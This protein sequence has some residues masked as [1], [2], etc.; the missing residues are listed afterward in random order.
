MDKKINLKINRLN[1]K[2]YFVVYYDLNFAAK[3]I[4]NFIYEDIDPKDY[5]ATNGIEQNSWYAT[6]YV[7]PN[8]EQEEDGAVSSDT[9]NGDNNTEGTVSNT[10]S[11]LN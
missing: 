10:Q 8:F 4:H 1:L 11:K 5:I 2:F 7:P 9:S 3:L 6:G